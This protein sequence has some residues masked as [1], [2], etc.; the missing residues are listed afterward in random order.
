VL[1]MADQD[2]IGRQRA[3]R[4]LPRNFIQMDQVV[5]ATSPKRVRGAQLGGSLATLAFGGIFVIILVLLRENLTAGRRGRSSSTELE[6][7]EQLPIWATA[8]AVK[9]HDRPGDSSTPLAEP[10]SVKSML[11]AGSSTRRDGADRH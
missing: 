8:S 10:S 3:M 1:E 4:L 11:P 6:P 5:D 9:W 7:R 2:L